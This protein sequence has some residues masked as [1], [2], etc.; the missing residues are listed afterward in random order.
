MSSG[1]HAIAKMIAGGALVILTISSLAFVAFSMT[2]L[3]LAAITFGT[4]VYYIV[5]FSVLGG[6]WIIL[7]VSLIWDYTSIPHK[8]SQDRARWGYPRFANDMYTFLFITFAG[9]GLIFGIILAWILKF[10]YGSAVPMDVGTAID[11]RSDW[12]TF[13][14]EL[15]IAACYVFVLVGIDFIFAYVLRGRFYYL[16][17]VSEIA[18]G[19]E[20]TG[21]AS[22]P[23]LREN[24]YP[25][26]TKAM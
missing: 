9:F 20:T 13:Q 5:L 3:T 2:D 15:T 1:S 17:P 14:T 22:M 11:Q 21:E 8:D 12:W 6:L 19:A 7:G 18:P 4:G 23:L 16:R 25:E 26:Y 10:G 24:E